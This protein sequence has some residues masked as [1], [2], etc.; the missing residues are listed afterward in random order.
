MWMKT[1]NYCKHFARTLTTL[2]HHKIDI[3]NNNIT[4]YT[5]LT[6]TINTHNTVIN[7]LCRSRKAKEE[8]QGRETQRTER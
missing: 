7:I 1:Q 8:A 2:C 5:L 4:K 3:D 6:K